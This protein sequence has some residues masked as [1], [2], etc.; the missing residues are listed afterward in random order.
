MALTASQV[1]SL[2]KAFVSKDNALKRVKAQAQENV[3]SIVGTAEMGTAAFGMGIIDGRFGGVEV[4]GMPLSLLSA[5]GSHLVG[6]LGVAP[7]H[8]HA[9]GNGFLA[10]YLTTLGNGVGARMLAEA[11]KPK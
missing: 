11:N 1:S 4:L 3:E 5:A 9:F 6:F 10:N 7:S 2:E 8:M